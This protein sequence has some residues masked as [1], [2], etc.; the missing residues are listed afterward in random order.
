MMWVAV[1]QSVEGV[2]AGLKFARE[3]C[4][5]VE[6]CA[7]PSHQCSLLAAAAVGGGVKFELGPHDVVRSAQNIEWVHHDCAGPAQKIDPG[8]HDVVGSAQKFE[9]G[10]P[11]LAALA[12]PSSAAAA[13]VPDSPT[14][15]PVDSNASS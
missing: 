10:P 8:P 1:S 12:A 4:W 15:L 13:S 14:S 3:L 7:R 2:G 6:Y 11:V 5:V 9:Q